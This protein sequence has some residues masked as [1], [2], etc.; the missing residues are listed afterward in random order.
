MPKT[1]RSKKETTLRDLEELRKR[2]K[3]RKPSKW[4]KKLREKSKEPRRTT[5]I[6]RMEMT[7]PKM[8]VKAQETHL[9]S[10]LRLESK[11]LTFLHLKKVASLPSLVRVH[12]ET[13]QRVT[14]TV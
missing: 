3:S 11:T 5:L 12:T 6:E 9:K 10:L 8:K 13:A 2:K 14:V 4:P 1:R 7:D